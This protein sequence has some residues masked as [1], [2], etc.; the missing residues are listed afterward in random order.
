MDDTRKIGRQPQQA[1]APA[2]VGPEAAQRLVAQGGYI[3][4]DVRDADAFEEGRP[5]GSV[6]V[7]FSSDR[8][9]TF[10]DAVRERFETD[11][12]L[13]VG[14]NSGKRSALAVL[15]LARAGFTNLIECR[16][17]WDGTRGPFGE[18]REPGWHRVGLPTDRGSPTHS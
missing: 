5:A 16:T 7:P 6:N 4:L 9:Q 2:Q 13:V 18:L 10:V 8:G 3:Y 15:A 17:G 14:C 12:R 11:S 1:A